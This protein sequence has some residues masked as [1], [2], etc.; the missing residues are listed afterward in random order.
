MKMI[1]DRFGADDV[2]EQ[3]STAIFCIAFQYPTRTEGMEA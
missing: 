3:H 2:S 1:E